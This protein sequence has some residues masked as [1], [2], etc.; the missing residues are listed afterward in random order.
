MIRKSL[1][2]LTAILVSATVVYSQVIV[3]PSVEVRP[4]K[5]MNAV[6]NGPKIAPASQKKGNFEAYKAANFPYARL[7]D[8]PLYAPWTKCVDITCIFPNFDADETKAESYDF[9]LTDKLLSDIQLSETKVFYRL[10]QSIENASKKYDVFPPKDYKKWA[11]I[12]EHIIRHYNE[13]W[14]NGFHYGIEYWEIWNEPDL[15]F[16]AGRHL[17]NDSP[18]WNGTDKEFFK[19]Y[20]TVSKYLKLQFPELK[21]GGPALCED[22]NWAENFLS[23]CSKHNVILDFFSYHLYAGTVEAFEQK[24][25][26][27]RSLLVKYGYADVEMILDEWNYLANWTDEFVYTTEVIASYV[28]AA[29]TS[30]VMQSTQDGPVSMLMYYDARPNTSF[31]GL[32]DPTSFATLPVYYSFY[33]WKRLREAGMQVYSST[34]DLKDLYVTASKGDDGKLF[35][36]VTSYS[37]DNNVVAPRSLDLEVKNIKINEVRSF[38][39]DKYKLYTETPVEFDNNKLSLVLSANSVTLIEIN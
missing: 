37:S 28:G 1:V 21:I 33:A 38:V 15:G 17:K 30:A 16:K 13:G 5:V 39:T 27:M 9:T 34:G 29:F 3:D 4:I 10:G 32:F 22:N 8:A 24:N 25:E 7:H 11:R 2:I 23:Y 18:T 35:I 31:N 20:E 19:F 26:L 14:A 6:N 12:C 36:L